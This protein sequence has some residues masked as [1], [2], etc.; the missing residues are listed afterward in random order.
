VWD[1]GD[2]PGAV[3]QCVCLENTKVV[4]DV[5]KDHFRNVVM[6]GTSRTW[7]YTIIPYTMNTWKQ[8]D[9]TNVETR[10]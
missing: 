7:L 9:E 8:D 4:D 1:R 5:V 2:G 10:P 3:S 6:N